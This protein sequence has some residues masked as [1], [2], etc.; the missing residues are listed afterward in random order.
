MLKTLICNT[1][2]KVINNLNINKDVNYISF[3]LCYFF[4]VN[5]KG[6]INIKTII[7]KILILEI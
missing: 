7:K 1:D 6:E 4:M 3:T 2:Y 5:K